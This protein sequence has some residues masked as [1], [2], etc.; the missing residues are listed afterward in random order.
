M[1]IVYSNCDVNKLA[2]NACKHE[3]KNLNNGIMAISTNLNCA[4]DITCPC[5]ICSKFGHTFNNGEE[6]QD[7]ATIRKSY[8]Q[9]R[10]A[11]QKIKGMAASQDRDV[12]FLRANKFSYVNSVDLLPPSSYHDSVATNRLDKLEG[13]LV[14]SIK[15]AD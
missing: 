3:K 12:N 2:Y 11:L 8:I 1:S 15:F 6:L 13:L 10:V 4:F 14:K 9:L 5:A 7:Q